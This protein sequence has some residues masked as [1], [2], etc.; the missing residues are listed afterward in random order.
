MR[1]KAKLK[2]GVTTVK[3]MAKHAMLSYDEAKKKK[4]KVNFITYMVAKSNGKTIYEV[5]TSQFMSKNPYIKF[6]FANGKKGDEIVITWKDLS[7]KEK[8]SK[9][10]IK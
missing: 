2:G 9:G 4:K 10:K 7:G 1:I 6:K 8:I 3:A 5:S